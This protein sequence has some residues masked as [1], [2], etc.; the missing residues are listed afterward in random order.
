MLA[1]IKSIPVQPELITKTGFL[2]D[3]VD[4][5]TLYAR[6]AEE[7]EDNPMSQTE[8]LDELARVVGSLEKQ[9]AL[10]ME[11]FYPAPQ[12]WAPA[13][14]RKVY[15]QEETSFLAF[16]VRKGLYDY[17]VETLDEQPTRKQLK[18]LVRCA[19][20]P[21]TISSKYSVPINVD[22]IK[23]FLLR[24][25]NDGVPLDWTPVFA[26]FLTSVATHWNTFSPSDRLTQLSVLHTF[27]ESGRI[28]YPPQS[29]LGADV[30][31]S[32]ASLIWTDFLLMCPETWKDGSTRSIELATKIIEFFLITTG[33]SDSSTAFDPNIVYKGSMLWGHFVHN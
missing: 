33:D 3:L 32:T 26:D 9:F 15:G 1:Q 20:Q 23:L 4:D 13:Q 8:V 14:Q 16:A 7:G 30:R 10:N 21:S 31:A 22:M 12:P 29:S 18:S 27:Q 17:V 11:I 5:L 24:D 25:P 28:N 19:L 6:L 2:S